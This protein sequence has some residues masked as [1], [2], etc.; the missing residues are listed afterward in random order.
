MKTFLI[1]HFYLTMVMKIKEFKLKRPLHM[2]LAVF[3][4]GLNLDHLMN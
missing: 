3:I 4:K 2:C 1:Y